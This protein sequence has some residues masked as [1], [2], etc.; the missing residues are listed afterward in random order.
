M[1]NGV[2]EWAKTIGTAGNEQSTAILPLNQSQYLVL[3]TRDSTGGVIPILT[4]LAALNTITG[5][6][7]IDLNGNGTKDAGEPF[8]NNA[9]VKSVRTDGYTKSSIVSDG[10]YFNSVGAG[11]YVTSV[12]FLHTYFTVSPL[13]HTS[14]FTGNFGNDQVTFRLTPNTVINDLQV[15]ILPLSAAR[16]GFAASYRVHYKNAGSTTLSNV[17]LELQKDSRV[18]IVSTTPT[19]QSL[20]GNTVS[21]NIGAVPIFGEGDIYINVQLPTP[22]TVNN[23]DRLQYSVKIIP[24]VTDNTPADNIDTLL[25][26]VTGSFDPND[27]TETHGGVITAAQVSGAEALTYLIRFQNTGTDTAFN[28]T[29]RDTLDA[30]LD[31][32]SLQMIASSHANQ[33]SITDGNKLSWQFNDIKLP[34]TGIDEP[35]SHGYIAYSI[36]PKPTVVPGDTIRNTAGI[37]FDYNL[38]IATNTEKT[39]VLLLSPLPVTL[40]LFQ[41]AEESGAVNVKWAT[42]IE[43]HV[44]QFEVM[45][46]SN[47]TD[48]ITLGTVQS[49]KGAYLF[50]DKQPLKGYN[51]YRLRSVDAD[52]TFS[53]S[54]IVLVNLKN[55]ADIMSSLYPNPATGNA[56]LKLQGAVEGNVVVQVLDQQ[57]RLITTK[58]FGVQHTAAFKTPLDLGYLARGSYVLRIMV[59][60]KT[61]LHK[62]L[63]Q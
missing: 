12:N 45:R 23:G 5:N 60:D 2:I 37:Y 11:T 51:Y 52:G 25:Q 46:S 38:P 42:S 63:I 10:A 18:N 40:T 59:N 58:Q 36:K 53:L 30:R 19:Y 16:P 20:T 24:P 48:F 15:S 57:G 6:V 35:N 44:K 7:F 61:Y 32:N 4:K 33:L 34:Y 47:G 17:T 13:T 1:D 28:I 43:E 41:A 22:P 8:Y 29:V 21:W 55:G 9:T 49:G 39:A 62:L 14:T 27:K 3:G 50:T 54:T 31:W 56:T 26:I